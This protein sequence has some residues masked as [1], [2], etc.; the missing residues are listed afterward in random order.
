[1]LAF[2]YMNIVD[3]R[4]A[5]MFGQIAY[6]TVS[7]N[8]DVGNIRIGDRIWVI[9]PEELKSMED[10]QL[11]LGDVRADEFFMVLKLLKE[12]AE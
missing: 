12:M 11:M 4:S 3:T 1:M 9:H 6:I 8:G 2:T 10:L 5:T 7:H